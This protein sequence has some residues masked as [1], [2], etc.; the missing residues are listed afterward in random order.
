M[1]IFG[2]EGYV[3]KQIGAGK[4]NT[5]YPL[6][7]Y[8][9]GHYGLKPHDEINSQGITNNLFLSGHITQLR[10]QNKDLLIIA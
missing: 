1:A 2:R 4:Q 9:K 3:N 5:K 10:T 7:Y 6:Q 8:P